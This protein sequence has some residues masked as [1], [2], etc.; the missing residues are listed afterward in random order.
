MEKKNLAAICMAIPGGIMFAIG[1]VLTLMTEWNLMIPGI[2]VGAIGALVLLLIYPI[3]R[4]VGHY[5]P[6]KTN[7]KAVVAVAIGI[8]GTILL[9]IGMCLVMIP[10]TVVAWKMILGILV[11][12]VGLV[13]V[14]LI[15]I[16]YIST[17][18]K[19]TGNQ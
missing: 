15:P 4:K 1:M 14:I 3:Y 12:M 11:G 16:I 10:Q 7:P 8:V 19:K 5:P 18:N 13:A 6:L 2:V 17:Q 9:G